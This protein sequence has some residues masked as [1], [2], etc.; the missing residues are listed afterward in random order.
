MGYNFTAQ[1]TQGS[2][3]HAP[4]ALSWHPTKNRYS[5]DTVAEHDAQLNPEVSISK[6]QALAFTESNMPACL[7]DLH[8]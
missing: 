1:W 2:N 7:Q 5:E 3:H 8:M 6:I 4:D